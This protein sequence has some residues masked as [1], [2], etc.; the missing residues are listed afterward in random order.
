[1]RQEK[2]SQR[3]VYSSLC[4]HF[5]VARQAKG[6]EEGFYKTMPSLKV[7]GFFDTHWKSNNIKNSS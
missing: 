4:P 3:G 6:D 1:V 5:P 7:V 2:D